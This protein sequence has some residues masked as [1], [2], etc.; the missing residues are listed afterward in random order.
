MPNLLR[1]LPLLAWSLVLVGAPAPGAVEPIPEP[2]DRPF[3]GVIRL[4][5]DATDLDH[6]V[7]QVRET[8]PV[9][10]PGPTTLYY[11]RW[12]P[13]NHSTTGPIDLLAGL[14]ITTGDGRRVEWRRDIERMHA[15][16]VEVPADAAQ[17]VLQ[18]QFLTPVSGD[19][20]RRV[21]T[22]DL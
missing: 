9:A 4:E 11:P 20:P 17:L 2:Q 19:W 7:F 12:L 15:F 21:I 18:F 8:I 6:R 14:V 1:N 22:P 10:A 13:G 16:H 3:A 5:V